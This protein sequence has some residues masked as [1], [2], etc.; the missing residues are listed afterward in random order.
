MGSREDSPVESDPNLM[1]G[2]ERQ[3]GDHAVQVR[4]PSSDA[5]V[6]CVHR[7]GGRSPYSQRL[8]TSQSECTPRV[9]EGCDLGTL[10]RGWWLDG[11]RKVSRPASMAGCAQV[12]PESSKRVGYETPRREKAAG[13][14]LGGLRCVWGAG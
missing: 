10:R 13:S 9:A 2:L 6:E 3:K 5:R 8:I 7:L 12:E 1:V 4:Q 14:D 11:V